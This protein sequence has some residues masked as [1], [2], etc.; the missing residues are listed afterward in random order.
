MTETIE[1]A[2]VTH[3]A[4]G[5]VYGVDRPKR[6]ADAIAWAR[7]CGVDEVGGFRQGFLTS[8]GRFVDRK[9]ALKLATAAGQMKNTPHP[10][11]DLF[12]EDVW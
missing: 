12:S 11:G 5:G 9:E 10:S 8:G 2:A 6:H 3:P 4:H 1:K 7:S